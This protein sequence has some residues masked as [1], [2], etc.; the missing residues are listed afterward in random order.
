MVNAEE[1][2]PYLPQSGTGPPEGDKDLPINRRVNTEETS[3]LPPPEG[4][5]DLPGIKRDFSSASG[6]SK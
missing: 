6:G 5:K 4:D 1:T 2:S 3:P